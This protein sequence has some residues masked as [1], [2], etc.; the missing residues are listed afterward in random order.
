MKSPEDLVDALTLDEQISLL[1][2]ADVWQTVAIPRAGIPSMRVTDGPAG[3]RGTRFDGERSINT[4]CGTLLAAT[5]DPA[6]VEE[7]GHVLGRE[8]KSKGA[9]V[10]LAPTVNLHRTPVGGRNFECMS[11]DPLLTAKT[12]VGF[13]RGLQSEGVAACIKHFVGNDTEFERMSIDSRIDE[14]T[15]R[16]MYLV[17]FEAAVKEAKVMSIM[18]AYNRINGPFAADST[19]LL[20]DILRGEWGF[21]GLVM[22]DWFGLHSTA[23]GINAG[24]DLEMPGPTRC[25]GDALAAAVEAGLVDRAAVRAAALNVVTLLART[26]TLGEAGPGPEH[27]RAD[28]DADLAIVR[29]AASSGMVL[30][31][32]RADSDGATT[33]PLVPEL[34]RR[35]ALIGPN[36]EFGQILGG[37]S[38]HVNPISVSTPLGALCARLAPLG[39]DVVHAPG[40][41][42]HRNLP[43]LRLDDC[44]DVVVEYY[45]DPDSLDHAQLAPD[46][47][48]TTSSSKM[49]WMSDPLSRPGS[50][51]PMGVR[52]LALFT[53]RVSGVWQFSVTATNLAA[54]VIDGR[55]VVDNA[56]AGLGG[57]FFGMG[58]N[59]A[60]GTVQLEAGHPYELVAELRCPAGGLGVAGLH[61]GA[62]APPDPYIMDHAVE[63]ARDA[64]VS[65]VVVGTNHDW[66]CEGWDRA[67]LDLPGEQNELVRRVAAASR[68][69]VVVV[70]AGSPVAMPWLADVDAVLCCW[71]PGQEMGNALVDV[72]LGDTE[73]Q[74]RLPVTFP[75]TLEDTPA[76]EHYP[77][78]AGVAN[79]G[80]G[81]LIGYR[82]YD[83]VGREPLFPF[84]FGLGYAKASITTA[85]LVNDHAI[86][87]TL[88]NTGDRDAVEVVQVYMHATKPPQPGSDTP[89]QTLVGFAK[90][91]VAKHSSNSVTI[92]VDPRA[93]QTW[94][95]S[96]H[97]WIAVSGPFVLRIG[98]SSR[99]IAVRL[100][101][102][103]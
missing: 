90:V 58:R 100:Q 63:A 64:D 93:Y 71:F 99:D 36:A 47:T 98:T 85:R 24:L 4:P 29:R 56:D 69:T 84:G 50:A 83:T 55:T 43:E 89:D 16:E 44:A 33:L 30:L 40:C 70:N 23:E 19:E 62:C 5:W 14:R 12:A 38:A 53:P 81:R 28:I 74:G 97:G 57:S 11:E 87:V 9:K 26:E 45:A 49:M 21:D 32:N 95:V 73:P 65:I 61:L 88:G 52:F 102:N 2:G 77:G 101:A 46:R 76:F 75:R 92:A 27:A 17:P 8:T 67:T 91:N 68:R 96:T 25:R 78:R 22:S 6:V 72:L 80:E 94:D 31:Q 15:M 82:W 86:E 59:E 34:L 79:Y 35:V 10:L 13:V 41:Y 60:V 42:I 39:V 18:T 54:L 1:A 20:V 3:A 103:G 7:I 37:G 51:L 66:E 48:D